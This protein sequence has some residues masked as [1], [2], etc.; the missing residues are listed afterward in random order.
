M[1]QARH[2]GRRGLYLLTA[3]GLSP[4]ELIARTR[5]ALSAGVAWL[6]YRGKADADVGVAHRLAAACR[7]AGT[8]FIV[9]D[10][11]EMAMEVG[12][13]G[14]HLGRSDPGILQARRLLGP[15]GIIGVSCYDDFERARMLAAQGADYLAFG[16]VFASPTKPQAPS[17]PLDVLTRARELGR[18]V[19]AIGGITA[20]KA[21]PV[22]D[23]GADLLAVIS[24]IYEAPDIAARVADYRVL[25]ERRVDQ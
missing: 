6:Q 2:V 21:G 3:N 18:P 7:R 15:E 10:D 20:E 14:V 25:F 23:A 9:N 1:K 8:T 5:R 17:C 22:I 4:E 24:D 11:P 16:S 19:V 13:D 12:A